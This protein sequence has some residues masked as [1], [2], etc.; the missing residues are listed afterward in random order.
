MKN[1]CVSTGEQL[2]SRFVVNFLT[3]RTEEAVEGLSSQKNYIA[4]W[5]IWSWKCCRL[6]VGTFTTHFTGSIFQKP[7][8]TGWDRMMEHEHCG[9]HVMTN[10]QVVIH[11]SVA[12]MFIA[13]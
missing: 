4:L 7:S 12:N 2:A 3:S 1:L 5:A 10:M 13:E 8:F 11:G 9:L 6:N